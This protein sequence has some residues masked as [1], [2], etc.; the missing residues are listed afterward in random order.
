MSWPAAVESVGIRPLRHTPWDQATSTVTTKAETVD[1]DYTDQ[2]RAGYPST[3]TR[4]G[5]F[6]RRFVAALYL[7]F[8]ISAGASTNSSEITDV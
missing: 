1:V 6:M 7:A 3:P 4:K 8:A 5:E 2:R